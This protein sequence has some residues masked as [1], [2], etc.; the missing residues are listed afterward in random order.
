M[1]VNMFVCIYVQN[2]FIQHV[3]GCIGKKDH[4]CTLVWY[5][6]VCSSTHVLH[7]YILVF[8]CLHDAWGVHLRVHACGWAAVGV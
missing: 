6:H 2:M 8:A 7:V 1:H 3:G 4:L 5:M